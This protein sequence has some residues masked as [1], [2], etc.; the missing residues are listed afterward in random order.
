MLT[1]SVASKE[2]E[3]LAAVD[4]ICELQQ[5]MRASRSPSVK[6]QIVL[7]ENE[8]GTNYVEQYP[9]S[10]VMDSTP[11]SRDTPV[12]ELSPSELM[13]VDTLEASQF[14]ASHLVEPAAREQQVSMGMSI[15]LPQD[16][17]FLSPGPG[18]FPLA[19]LSDSKD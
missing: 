13:Q 16:T 6:R 10:P 4:Q 1:E 7:S 15:G 18:A 9:C 3:L 19:V 11:K 5:Q 12:V 14:Q 17:A 2:E 8:E